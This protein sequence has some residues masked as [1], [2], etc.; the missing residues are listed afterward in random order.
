MTLW[1]GDTTETRAMLHEVV[2]NYPGLNRAWMTL[3]LISRTGCDDSFSMSCLR[4]AR[5]LD[6]N[7]PLAA[8]YLGECY[9]RRD[10][11]REAASCY[12]QAVLCW[13]Y[14]R[15]MYNI[16]AR[17]IYHVR[18][19]ENEIYPCTLLPELTPRLPMDRE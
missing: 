18:M 14:S 8:Y 12:E 17:R 15:S 4:K 11:S 16:R 1:L 19:W 10:Q 7:D 2:D 6:M 5:L 9:A 13:R 3:G